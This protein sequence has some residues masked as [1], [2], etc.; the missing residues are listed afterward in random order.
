M[1]MYPTIISRNNQGVFAFKNQWIIKCLDDEGVITMEFH[2]VECLYDFNPCQLCIS[3]GFIK[4]STL[5]ADEEE[6]LCISMI[7]NTMIHM[8]LF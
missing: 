2:I 5:R 7:L 3:I 1:H 4:S 6:I 8:V